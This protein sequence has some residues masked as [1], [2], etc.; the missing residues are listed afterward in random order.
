[1]LVKEISEKELDALIERVRKAKADNLA[2]TAEDM[3]LV[4]EMLINF[5]HLQEQLSDNDI[6]LHKLK[7]LAGLI[8]SSE[9]FK[10][11][12][13]AKPDKKLESNKEKKEKPEIG[14]Y[15]KLGVNVS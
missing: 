8:K 2:L 3:E 15:P 5:A 11:S 14:C 6:T 10:N 7:K 12:D 13:K 9:K 1:M 4:L